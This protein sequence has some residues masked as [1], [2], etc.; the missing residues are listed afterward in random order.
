MPM[1]KKDVIQLQVNMLLALIE[2]ARE[3]ARI[4]AR[5]DSQNEPEDERPEWELEQE[6]YN[7]AHDITSP[8]P[9]SFDFR[10][11][12]PDRH[13]AVQTLTVG[14]WISW[15][16]VIYKDRLLLAQILSLSEDDKMPLIL[17]NDECLQMDSVR[18]LQKCDTNYKFQHPDEV[19]DTRHHFGTE[20]SS[21]LFFFE[22]ASHVC[23]PKG[24]AYQ[25]L[26][27][28]RLLNEDGSV[29][30]EADGPNQNQQQIN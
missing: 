8:P 9:K 14:D 6:Q 24:F 2:D 4:E 5:N 16:H 23:R 1:D 13:S 27:K 7:E 26:N 12:M 28:F 3:L 21:A 15:D 25:P 11:L 10:S 18:V 17:S 22:D 29:Y 20:A 19:S 30:R